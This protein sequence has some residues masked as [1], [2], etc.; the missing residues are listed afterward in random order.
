[1][2]KCMY[3][4]REVGGTGQLCPSCAQ[5]LGLTPGSGM[6][7]ASPCL[8]CQ[9][10]ELV[11]ALVRELTV[12]TGLEVSRAVPMAVSYAPN[13]HTSFWSGNPLGVGG[14][15]DRRPLGILEMYVCLKCGYTEWY[16]RDPGSIPIGEQYGTE[17]IEATEGGPYR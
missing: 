4:E 6:R 17:K 1:V 5:V 15:N 11:R 2:T 8:R 9:H 7:R 14:L 3:C 10:P 12:A 16:C 13:V